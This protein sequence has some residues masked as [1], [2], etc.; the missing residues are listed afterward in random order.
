[1]GTLPLTAISFGKVSVVGVFTNII[2]LPLVGASVSLGLVTALFG[3]WAMP[4]AAAVAA[5][6]KIL[7]SLILETAHSTGNLPW[8]SVETLRFKPLHALPFYL[9]M[10]WVFHL[11]V[12]KLSR[13]LLVLLLC[14]FVMLAFVPEEPL[15]TPPKNAVRV[16]FI[17]VGQG[18]AALVQFPG[19][20]TMLI[21]AGM[22]SED[23]DAGA[24]IVVPFLKRRGIETID[25]FVASHPHADHIGGSPAV[26]D[27]FDVR[28][29]IE[30]GQT[31]SDPVYERYVKAVLDE[32]AAV[33]RVKA[34][35]RALAVDGARVYFLYPTSETV[36]TDSS[37]FPMNLNNSSVVLKLTYGETSF[38]FVGDLEREGEAEL[39]GMFGF[40]L[41][42]DVLKVGH[43]GSNTSTT[44]EFLDRVRP[45]YAVI[46]VGRNNRFNH[47]SDEVLERLNA[48]GADVLRTD[49]EGAVIFETDGANVRRIEWR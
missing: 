18:D 11:P 45:R 37:A 4:L 46:S 29:V 28:E 13:V 20:R 49:E 47:P 22:W 10:L 2:V 17:D 31:A 15:G 48:M 24:Y 23:Y 7:L 12:K 35:D 3:A 8:A 14:S 32:H 33:R 26:F 41:R 21:D 1:L 38:L 43:H 44:Q 42:A 9:A 36:R 6:I 19:G 25:W 39:S 40:F 16:S 34:C 27:A 5:A 30:S